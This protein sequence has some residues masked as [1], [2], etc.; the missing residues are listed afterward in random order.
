MVLYASINTVGAYG[1]FAEALAH[2]EASRVS[3]ILALTPLMAVATVELVH[4]LVPEVLAGESIRAM[5]W[6]GA[7]LVVVGSTFASLL[8]R[9][10]APAPVGAPIDAGADMAPTD[11]RAGERPAHRLSGN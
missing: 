3:A 6:L 4:W 8:G 10:A 2:W 11:G 7:A 1:A 5:G 9:R